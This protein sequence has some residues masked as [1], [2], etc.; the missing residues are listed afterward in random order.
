MEERD[1]AMK[2]EGGIT[3]SHPIP[4]DQGRDKRGRQRN[5]PLLLHG[6]LYDENKISYLNNRAAVETQHGHDI[7]FFLEIPDQS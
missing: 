4:S 6:S 5:D 1:L 2:H 3:M 7:C